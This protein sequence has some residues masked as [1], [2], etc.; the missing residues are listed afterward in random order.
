MYLSRLPTLTIVSAHGK[1]CEELLARAFMSLSRWHCTRYSQL[2]ILNEHESRWIRGTRSKREQSCYHIVPGKW[3]NSRVS[4][5]FHVFYLPP[6]PGEDYSHRIHLIHVGYSS[7]A[8]KGGYDDIFLVSKSVLFC[9]RWCTEN[10]PCGQWT[11][12]YDGKIKPNQILDSSR[13]LL[14]GHMTLIRCLRKK[15]SHRAHHGQYP[16]TR[17]ATFCSV[18][19]L[20]L[21]LSNL[22]K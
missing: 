3:S 1:W 6:Y 9:R 5:S 20:F 22:Q 21:V 18:S 4:G 7:E 10:D 19:L 15:N 14:N 8:Y 2:L 12:W 16:S 11:A 17:F 13:N